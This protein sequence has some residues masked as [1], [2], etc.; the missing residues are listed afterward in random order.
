VAVLNSLKCLVIRSLLLFLVSIPLETI[1][2]QQESCIEIDNYTSRQQE[3]WWITGASLRDY[4][5]HQSLA[6]QIEQGKKSHLM[7]N[8]LFPIKGHALSDG[9]GDVLVYRNV[10]EGWSWLSDSGDFIQITLVV[11]KHL[12][13][14]GEILI[15]GPSGALVF[16]TGGIPSFRSYCFGYA[17]K[18]RIIYNASTK[19]PNDINNLLFFKLG[20]HSGVWAKIDAQFILTDSDDANQ[21]CGQCGFNANLIFQPN[22]SSF[23]NQQ[24]E[25]L[26]K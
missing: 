3:A 6:S 16:Y 26:F 13:G 4:P 20:I 19:N 8:D 10:F 14:S 17:T 18:G 7:K 15:G 11:P 5:K 23:V 1:A 2:C 25:K 9:R 24:I 12:V 21:A 22:S